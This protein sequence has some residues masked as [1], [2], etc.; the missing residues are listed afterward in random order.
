MLAL[1]SSTATYDVRRAFN[2]GFH[3]YSTKEVGPELLVR[4]A[5]LVAAGH[6]FVDQEIAQSLR[7]DAAVASLDQRHLEILQ[8][9]A[10]GLT[11]PEVAASIFVGDRQLRRLER[12]LCTHLNARTVHHAVALAVA[13]GLVHARH[14]VA[15]AD[16]GPPLAGHG[17]SE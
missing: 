15:Y 14:S 12:R 7:D 17:E 5:E 16:D 6:H 2:A 10:R 9:Y 8:G 3:G 4:R 1:S 13:M 11:R